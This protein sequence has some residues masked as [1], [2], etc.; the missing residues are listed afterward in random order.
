MQKNKKQMKTRNSFK[1]AAERTARVVFALAAGAALLSGCSKDDAPD[2]GGGRVPVSF[3]AGIQLTDGAASAYSAA[4]E[5]RTTGGGDQWTAGDA[6]GVFMLTAGGSLG[7]DITGAGT[8]NAADNREYGVT[9]ATGALSPASGTPIYYPQSGNVDFIA[10]YPYGE[11]GTGDGKVTVDYKY[12]ISASDQSDPA[13]IDVLWAKA[14]NRASSKT[15]V[16]LTFAHVM[17]KVTFNVANGGGIV[18]QDVAGLAPG[19]VTLTGMPASATLA[20]QDGTLTAGAKGDIHPMK[21]AAAAAGSRATFSAVVVPQT[22]TNAGR[23]LKFSIAGSVYLWNIPAGEVFEAGTHYVYPVTVNEAGIEVGAPSIAP[24]TINDNGSGDATE[25]GKG[26][27][28]VFIPA[29]TFLMGSPA[30][31]PNRYTN[32]TQHRV[33]LTKDFYMSKYE[34]TNA[35]YVEF[36]NAVKADANG[37]FKAADYSAGKHPGTGLVADCSTGGRSA[38]GVQ[39]DTNADKWVPAAGYENYP[40]IY[41]TW[42]GADEYAHW[43]GGSLPT[44][45]QWEYACRGGQT[46]SLPFGL[47]DGTKL[48][49]DMANFNGSYPYE[50]PGGHINGYQG[51]TPPNTYLGKTAAVGSYPYANGYGLYNMHG[52]VIEWCSDWYD[53]YPAGPVTDPVGSNGGFYRVLRGGDWGYNARLCRSAYRNDVYPDY[54]YDYV[55]FRVVFE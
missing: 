26:I 40:V 9:P 8:A 30:D 13:T 2:E 21:A 27:E 53:T 25:I 19:D 45:A 31:E 17:S 37:I 23:S 22:G 20:L 6:V 7:G 24:W 38:W 44:E 4:P 15:A 33:T 48:Y 32:E 43:A 51:P 5:T 41:V 50:L 12:N 10:Y 34:I 3:S 28:K 29:G 18:A 36:L 14:A 49:A 11:K 42:Y 55:G 47:G 46:E 54:A 35:Q 16:A 52:N 1:Y 39:Y